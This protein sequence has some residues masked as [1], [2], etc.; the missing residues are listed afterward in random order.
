MEMLFTVPLPRAQQRR[1]Q[2]I[3]SR[4]Q[5]FLTEKQVSLRRAN[6]EISQEIGCDKVLG[7]NLRE[8][9]CG[10][11]GGNGSECRNVTGKVKRRTGRRLD[12]EI[13]FD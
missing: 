5:D 7:S 6:V 11:C 8:D 2:R 1:Q 10:V 4:T 13:N 3:Y 9:V 12:G